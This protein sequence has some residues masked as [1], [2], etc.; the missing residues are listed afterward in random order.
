MVKITALLAAA[1]AALAVVAPAASASDSTLRAAIKSADRQT[2]PASQRF[3]NALATY[4][5]TKKTARAHSATKRLVVAIDAGKAK[6]ARQKASTSKVRRG[7]T[8]YLSALTK[9]TSGL[10]S[11]DAALASID[12]GDKAGA[13]SQLKQFQTKS[14][15]AQIQGAKA[16]RLIGLK[17]S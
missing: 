16:A 1:M 11:F 3:S 17:A 12:A 15:K 13:R 14:T 7:R 10:K 8:M 2:S 4:A 9:L 5:R 6:I